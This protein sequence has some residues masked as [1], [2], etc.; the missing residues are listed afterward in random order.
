MLGGIDHAPAMGIF[1]ANR[2]DAGGVTIRDNRATLA[3]MGLS[4][5]RWHQGWRTEHAPPAFKPK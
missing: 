4:C 5:L 3:S 2:Q 1:G